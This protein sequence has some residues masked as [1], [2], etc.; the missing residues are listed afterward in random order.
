MQPPSGKLSQHLG[1]V[2]P[3]YHGL[4]STQAIAFS[5]ACILDEAGI[6][7]WVSMAAA[8]MGTPRHSEIL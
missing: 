6:A 7:D 5:H 3:P 8:E 2:V 1:A 4:D